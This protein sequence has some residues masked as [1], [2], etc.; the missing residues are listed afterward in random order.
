MGDVI[1]GRQGRQQ[2]AMARENQAEQ[3]ANLAAERKRMEAQR[4]RIEAVEAGQRN[5]LR[6]GG[7]G[8]LAFLEEEETPLGG[9]AQPV[10][11]QKTRSRSLVTY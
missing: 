5:V 6:G 8:M 9:T 11:S 7:G 1:T 10:G 4:K 2:M 3:R